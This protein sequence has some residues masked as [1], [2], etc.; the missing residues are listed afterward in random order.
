MIEEIADLI[1]Q[2]KNREAYEKMR[3]H[4]G[5]DMWHVR[6]R[7][8]AARN[9]PITPINHDILAANHM[10]IIKKMFPITKRRPV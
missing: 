3:E 7:Q 1:V 5:L 6:E 10:R 4:F 9:A 2:G 8:I